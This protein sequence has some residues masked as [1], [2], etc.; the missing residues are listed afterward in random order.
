MLYKGEI[1]YLCIYYQDM[2]VNM[3]NGLK[4]L[5]IEELEDIY[6]SEIQFVNLL[7]ELIELASYPEL[8]SLIQE[9]FT[10]H[11]NQ[12]QRVK[13]IFVFMNI[14]LQENR[15]D[16]MKG[17]VQEAYELTSNRSK[18]PVLDAAI[19]TVL[20]KMLHYQMT[21]YGS[22][23]S[24]AKYLD[25]EGDVIELLY[26][27]LNEDSAADKKLTKIAEGSFFSSGVYETAA[28]SSSS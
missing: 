20:Q 12:L 5:F 17:M 15:C 1:A 18:S 10:K 22:L 14:D 23:C 6:S 7:S 13:D 24:F 26:D 28:E 3:N 25:L 8:K 21:S 9:Q 11:R 4:E 16:A 27:T 19:I 2:E